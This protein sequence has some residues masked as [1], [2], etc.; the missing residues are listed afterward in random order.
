METAKDWDRGAD[1]DKYASLETEAIIKIFDH[2][3]EDDEVFAQERPL[4]V[5]RPCPCGCD[6]RDAPDIVGYVHAIRDGVG[7][8]IEIT[9]EET[10]QIVERV[11][12]DNW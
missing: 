11:F 6:N 3:G 5:Q 4:T 2:S 1:Q 10:Y 8:T 12:N 7:V 9:D